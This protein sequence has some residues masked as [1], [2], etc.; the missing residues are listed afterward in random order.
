LRSKLIDYLAET[1]Q[2]YSQTKLQ[3]PRYSTP[4]PN[5][6]EATRCALILEYLGEI[7]QHYT[8]RG[9][10]PRILDVGCGRGWL[11][12]LMSVLGDC[13]GIEPAGGAIEYAKEL[14]PNILF[15]TGTID[16]LLNSPGFVTYDIIVSSEV[17]E[18]VP[19][20]HKKRFVQE[21]RAALQSNG[22]CII[23]TPRAELFKAYCRTGF[24]LQPIEEW[25]TEKELKSLFIECGFTVVKHDRVRP[26]RITNLN[27]ALLSSRFRA[28]LS[29]LRIES[30]I[31]LLDYVASFYQVWWFKKG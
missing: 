2:Y 25:L 31:P 30:L 1:N 4:Y 19:W 29:L 14:F 5:A 15:H 26:R 20:A 16:D 3:D 13:E 18:H 8:R 28:I 12:N 10:T 24:E 22:H 9:T 7:R 23:T 21:L 27:R 17:I 11:T 6:E